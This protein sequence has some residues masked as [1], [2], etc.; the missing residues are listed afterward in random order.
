MRTYASCRVALAVLAAGLGFA[1]R[2]ENAKFAP[3]LPG[4]PA[5]A[6]PAERAITAP[7]PVPV[8]RLRLPSLVG[9][10][11]G[12]APA[13]PGAPALHP[14]WIVDPDD[15]ALNMRVEER[16]VG[17]RRVLVLDSLLR[18]SRT[19]RATWIVVDAIRVPGAADSLR[20]TT[21]CGYEQA[22]PS[23]RL[24]ALVRPADAY[25]I[26][27]IRAAWRV[28]RAAQHFEDASLIGLRCWN[29]EWGQ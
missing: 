8:E 3:D 26:R 14:A 29:E 18:R 17:T 20:I 19:G 1:C 16:M 28:N 10:V 12:D 27:D 2:H 21:F 24:V 15:S 9:R 6:A 22:E 7:P 13:S 5:L 25:E 4:A 11:L 23:R